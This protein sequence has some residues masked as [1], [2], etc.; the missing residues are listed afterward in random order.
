MFSG[1]LGIPPSACKCS[2]E[3]LPPSL[4]LVALSILDT[5]PPAALIQHRKSATVLLWSSWPSENQSTTDRV[6]AIKTKT[7]A[8]YTA[9]VFLLKPSRIA[10]WS[11]HVF[12]HV[13]QHQPVSQAGFSKG[14]FD[15]YMS[16]PPPPLRAWCGSSEGWLLIGRTETPPLSV[17]KT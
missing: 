9:I 11:A 16:P 13:V 17:K 6:T 14:G 7:S 3:Q 4:S 2:L 10:L 15:C 5:E 8:S 12:L 1:S